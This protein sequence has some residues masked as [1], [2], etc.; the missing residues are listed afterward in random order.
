MEENWTGYGNDHEKWT[1]W[2]GCCKYGQSGRDAV[3]G[4]GCIVWWFENGKECDEMP[5][6][7]ACRLVMRWIWI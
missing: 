4:R 6:D 2:T 3:L 5:I 1:E 7:N